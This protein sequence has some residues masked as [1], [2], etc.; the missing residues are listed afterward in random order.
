MPERNVI[1]YRTEAGKCYSHIKKQIE[2]FNLPINFQL[3]NL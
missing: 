2:A 1:A 3:I